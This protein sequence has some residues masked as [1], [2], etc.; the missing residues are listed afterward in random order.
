MIAPALLAEAARALRAN[1][2][3][4]LLT[5]LG[6][7][8]GVGA[9]VV[10]L[11]VGQGA[12]A[13]VQQQ[14]ASMG[15]NLLIVLSGASSTS[16]VRI[17]AGTT[18]TLTFNDAIAI[19]E[20][21]SVAHAAPTQPGTAQAVFGSNNWSTSITGATPAYFLVRDW[22]IVRGDAFTEAEVRSGARVAL[23]GH[24]AARNLF[25]D[26][27]P[28]GK[29]LRIK[30]SPFQVIGLLSTK[31]QSLDGRDQDDS[32]IIPLTTAQKQV[33]GNRFPGTV[34]FIMVQA[35]SAAQMDVAERELNQLLRQ[36]H[37]IRDGQEDDFT[38]RNLTSLAQA[39]AASTRVLAILLG[40]IASVSLLVGGIGIMNIMLVSVTERTREIGIRMAIGA[41]RNDILLQFLLEALMISLA[42]SLIGA[43]LGIIGAWGAAQALQTQVIV[44]GGSLAMAF[45]V[46]ACI[47]IFFGYY[48]ARKAAQLKPIEALRYQ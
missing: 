17:G 36:R 41:R 33:F 45:G 8:I 37:R 43:I 3:R 10:M 1:R 24:T 15:S 26:S 13:M 40:T 6:I 16:G 47:G 21:P 18:P 42:G 22:N 28:V 12:Q 35:A 7:I 27:D 5:M 44:S 32:I 20:L 25:G 23:L 19:A 30:N 31:G 11:A 4:S 38:V 29:T 2:L 48:P 9:V 46:A 14:I 34:R 39:A